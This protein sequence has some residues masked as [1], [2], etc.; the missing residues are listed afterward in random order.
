MRL[1]TNDPEYQSDNCIA[2]DRTFLILSNPC[3]Q[4][5]ATYSYNK[6]THD[7]LEK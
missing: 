7:S 5:F 3:T 2:G 6:P 4:T 1:T